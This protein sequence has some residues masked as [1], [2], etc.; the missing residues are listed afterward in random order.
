MSDSKELQRSILSFLDLYFQDE[1]SNLRIKVEELLPKEIKSEIEEAIKDT[2]NLDLG[3]RGSEL[4]HK[5]EKKW[6]KSPEEGAQ[7]ISRQPFV[8]WLLNSLQNV[9]ESLFEN[10]MIL[11]WYVYA[12]ADER[13][14]DSFDYDS[15]GCRLHLARQIVDAT[16]KQISDPR[17]R[18]ILECMHDMSIQFHHGVY[19]ENA[20][21]CNNTTS[22]HRHAMEHAKLSGEI[23]A[24]LESLIKDNVT[25]VTTLDFPSQYAIKLTEYLRPVEKQH[26]ALAQV[27]DLM[28]LRRT[29]RKL[30]S[31]KWASTKEELWQACKSLEESGNFEESSQLRAH[32]TCLNLHQ[33]QVGLS[34]LSLQ[35]LNGNFMYGFFIEHDNENYSLKG[36]DGYF[37]NLKEYLKNFQGKQIEKA[38]LVSITEDPRPDILESSIGEEHFQNVLLIFEDI[39]LRE[40]STIPEK[41]GPVIAVLTPKL[42]HYALGVGML[43]FEF[44]QD[45]VSVSEFYALKNMVTR[46]SGQYELWAFDDDGNPKYIYNQTRLIDIADKIISG[47]S[48]WFLAFCNVGRYEPKP[49]IDVKQTWFTHFEIYRIHDEKGKQLDAEDLVEH[50]EYGGIIAYQRADRS[51]MD[52]WIN[53]S[54]EAMH[55]P[56]LAPIRAH[57]GDLYIISENHSIC[58][59]PD[60]PKFIVRQYGETSTWVFLIRCLM[61][62]CMEESHRVLTILK[63]DLGKSSSWLQNKEKLEKKKLDQQYE[64]LI[65][66]REEV[67][68]HRMLTISILEHAVSMGVSQYADHGLLLK[69]AFNE[70]GIIQIIDRLQDR[71]DAMVAIQEGITVDMEEL[72]SRQNQ[73]SQQRLNLLLLILTGIQL[74]VVLDVI[75]KVAREGSLNLFVFFLSVLISFGIIWGLIRIFTIH[76]TGVPKRRDGL[77]NGEQK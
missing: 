42:Y 6:C 2:E 45:E 21:I 17:Q 18:K 67:Q 32:I 23:I 73:V 69:R 64:G 39:I 60:D 61:L 9:S 66:K 38:K 52:D 16:I 24:Q 12:S 43:S 58:Y 72:K 1:S 46:H 76:H 4:W 51:S 36:N 20:M 7:C 71:T 70:T 41:L 75:F 31:D 57:K 77:K 49:W 13:W 30:F 50:F 14:E 62:Y 56:N 5:C 44:K 48:E 25:K 26:K 22:F 68:R 15:I 59:L 37:N 63:K 19:I 74:V 53:L 11:Y 65:A 27:G 47:Y 28:K 34:P 33:K 54:V 3:F 35:E 55:L 10:V 29:D 8:N 40:L